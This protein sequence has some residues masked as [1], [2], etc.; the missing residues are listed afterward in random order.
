L[1]PIFDA[2]FVFLNGALSEASSSGVEVE[3]GLGFVTLELT[4]CATAVVVMGLVKSLLR[5]DEE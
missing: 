4:A 1:T 5:D 2:E 3:L